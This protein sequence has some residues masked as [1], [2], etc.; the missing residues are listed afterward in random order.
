[1]VESTP[2]FRELIRGSVCSVSLKRAARDV[3]WSAV[4]SSF[5]VV[6]YSSKTNKNKIKIEANPNQIPNQL[7]SNQKPNDVE[8]TTTNNNKSMARKEDATRTGE[9]RRGIRPLP[10]LLGPMRR[11]SIGNVIWGEGVGEKGKEMF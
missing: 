2:L 7:E 3:V 10:S 1:M 9:V 11:T 8:T 6:V 4:C 5:S